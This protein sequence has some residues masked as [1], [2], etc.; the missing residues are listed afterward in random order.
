MSNQSGFLAQGPRTPGTVTAAF[1]FMC[2]GGGLQ[3]LGVMLNMVNHVSSSAFAG[4][5]T[6]VLWFRVAFA[7][8]AGK[9]SARTTASVLFGIFTVI[10]L[11]AVA[12]VG[13]LFTGSA[14]A[15]FIALVIFDWLIA[16]TAFVLLWLP[17]SRAHFSA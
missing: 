2:V 16:L 15:V 14:A 13:H 10:V 3:A 9:R 7:C 4:L 1:I 12:A 6:A 5:A 11:V 8:R 17:T